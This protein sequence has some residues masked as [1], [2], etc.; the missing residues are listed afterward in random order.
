MKKKQEHL[1]KNR[2]Q[3]STTFQVLSS[4]GFWTVHAWFG[5][6]SVVCRSAASGSGPQKPIWLFTIPPSAVTCLVPPRTLL[7]AVLSQLRSPN[8]RNTFYVHS[9]F[10]AT[11]PILSFHP[12]IQKHSKPH[13]NHPSLTSNI[14]HPTFPSLIFPFPTHPVTLSNNVL[15]ALWVQ[16]T[17]SVSTLTSSVL[18]SQTVRSCRRRSQ[19]RDPVFSLEGAPGPN[20]WL[21]RCSSYCY[22]YHWPWRTVSLRLSVVPPTPGLC[23]FQKHLE[24]I[25]VAALWGTR[26]AFLL[27]QTA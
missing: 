9:F 4:G 26:E 14:G 24:V 27:S 3:W 23:W 10:P 12:H 15:R 6:V 25:Y 1:H 17:T 22:Y 19:V 20:A 2:Q 8:P 7:Q 5:W 13:Y 16:S 11:A 18:D 21:N